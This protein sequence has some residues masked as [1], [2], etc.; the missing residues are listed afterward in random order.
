MA[1]AGAWPL[2]AGDGSF[3]RPCAGGTPSP[4]P[5]RRPLAQFHREDAG[6][7]SGWAASCWVVWWFWVGGSSPWVPGGVVPRHGNMAVG[8]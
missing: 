5:A 4:S 7:Y 2:V 6:G 8:G 1:L 3:L